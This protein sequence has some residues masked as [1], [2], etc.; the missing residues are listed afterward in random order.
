MGMFASQ[1][2]INTFVGITDSAGYYAG[3]KTRVDVWFFVRLLV[4]F[5]E[6]LV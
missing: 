6:P 4:W 5:G 1:G 2:E 3:S